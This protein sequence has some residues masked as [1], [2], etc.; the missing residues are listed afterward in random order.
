MSRDIGVCEFRRGLIMLRRRTHRGRVRALL[1]LLAAIVFLAGLVGAVPLLAVEA[2]DPAS[3]TWS[4]VAPSPIG[5]SEGVGAAVDGK[6]YVFGGY[7]DGTSI[8]KSRRGDVYDPATD[9]WTQL[10]D[11]PA[12]LTH[13][14]VAV[15]GRD[16]Y[17]AGGVVGTDTQEKVNAV[18]NVWKYNVD[19]DTWSNVTPLPQ[20]R[21][22]G[23]LVLLGRSLHF[24]G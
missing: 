12:G 8:P 22:A 4:T 15:D 5:L 24:F 17:F 9:S 14:G 2:A 16:I 10:A 19:T 3:L 7:T 20:P 23:A 11:A 21:G 18:T 6:L 13:C 1:S